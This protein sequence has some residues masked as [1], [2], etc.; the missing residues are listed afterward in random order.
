MSRF[1]NGGAPSICAFCNKPFPQVE[2]RIECFRGEDNRY[3]CDALC[4]R[5]ADPVPA[6]P[7]LRAVS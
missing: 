2:N 1:I 4:A 6:V 5:D 7:K 3:Y